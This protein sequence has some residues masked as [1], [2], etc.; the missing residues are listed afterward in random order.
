MFLHPAD[1]QLCFVTARPRWWFFLFA[2]IIGSLNTLLSPSCRGTLAAL[3]LA[4]GSFNSCS[5]EP[6][7]RNRND[8]SFILRAFAASNRGLD[9]RHTRAAGFTRK[10]WFRIT[11]VYHRPPSRDVTWVSRPPSESPLSPAGA[12]P[13][14]ERQEEEIR[15][16][17]HRE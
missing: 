17:R 16:F 2:R 4:N 3:V 10:F 13:K 14:E 9:A 15:Q 6:S 12:E 5:T 1:E 11:H 7:Q 8:N